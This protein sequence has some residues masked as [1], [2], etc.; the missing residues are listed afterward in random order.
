MILL[1]FRGILYSP[2]N[3]NIKNNIKSDSF[4]YSFATPLLERGT[5]MRYIL[6]LLEYRSSKTT[7]GRNLGLI[8]NPFDRFVQN[9]SGIGSIRDI[10]S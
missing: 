5:D 3:N 2:S 6:E 1:N 7:N 10:V 4:R 9:R 8:Q